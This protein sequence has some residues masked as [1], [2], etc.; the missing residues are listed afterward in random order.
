M[1]LS[2]NRFIC[3]LLYLLHVIIWLTLIFGLLLVDDANFLFF[4]IFFSVCIR[5]SWLITG[6][7][8]LNYLENAFD[9]STHENYRN[10]YTQHIAEW[11]GFHAQTI[12]RSIEIVVSVCLVIG[13][14][15]LYHM[16]STRKHFS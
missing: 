3:T 7:C 15:R 4:C 6:Y 1:T 10:K 13:F 16:L 2:P 9:P 8:L 14:Y 11:I 12:S 5:I